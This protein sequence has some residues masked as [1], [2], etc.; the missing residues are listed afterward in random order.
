MSHGPSIP[1]DIKTEDAAHASGDEGS[2]VLGVRNDT[3]T[4]LTGSNGD[5]SPIATDQYGRV[6]VKIGSGT[7]TPEIIAAFTAPAGRGLNV[8]AMGICDDDDS[9]SVYAA[10]EDDILPIRMTPSG[11][12]RVTPYTSSEVEGAPILG[13]LDDTG[14]GVPLENGYASVRITAARGAHVNLRKADGTEHVG[15]EAKADSIPIVLPTEQDFTKQDSAA[16][17]DETDYVATVAGFYQATRGAVADGDVGALAMTAKRAAIVHIDPEQTW[18]HGTLTTLMTGSSTSDGQLQSTTI[19]TGSADLLCDTPRALVYVEITKT[20]SPTRFQL[21]FQWSDDDSTYW[22][23]DIGP[24]SIWTYGTTEVSGTY[25]RCFHIPAMGRYLRVQA[26]ASGTASGSHYF[27][28]IVKAKA[29]Y[30]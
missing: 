29:V 5:Y 12:V 28:V 9:N 13:Q 7:A 14:T 21:F 1:P 24:Y 30:P 25:R 27:T 20:G 23:T 16:F 17:N 18:A 11:A 6:L 19:Q 26:Q 22:T 8:V 15:Q 4:A 2:F 10:G 3:P